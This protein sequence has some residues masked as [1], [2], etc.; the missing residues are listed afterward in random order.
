MAGFGQG[1]LGQALGAAGQGVNASML[2]LQFMNQYGA[3]L[4]LVPGSTYSPDFRGTQSS[5][6]TGSEYQMGIG[7]SYGSVPFGMGK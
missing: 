7:G 1:G 6:K 4:G 5:T 2:P 3:A